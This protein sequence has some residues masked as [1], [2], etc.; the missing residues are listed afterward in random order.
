MKISRL[1]YAWIC[2]TWMSLGTAAGAL[3]G[4]VT[5]MH[6]D[7]E[8]DGREYEAVLQQL[9]KT[10]HAFVIKATDPLQ[11]ILTVGKRNLQWLDVINAHRG[12]ADKL[13]LSTVDSQV[14]IPIE[15]PRESNRTIVATQ[16]N[17]LKATLPKE[18]LAVLL[19][20][21]PLTD[22]VPVDDKTF[23]TAI[24]DVDRVY[25]MA[26][27]WLLQE[28]DLAEYATLSRK[29][30]RGYYFLNK[31]EELDKK[32]T[33]WFDQPDGV[34]NR[35]TPL[36]VNICHNTSGSIKTCSDLLT[37]SIDTNKNAKIFYDKYVVGARKLYQTFF[38]IRNPR[39][40]AI[41]SAD[42][43]NSFVLPFRKPDKLD[44]ENWLRDNIQDEW[45]LKA[46]QLT[47]NFITPGTNAAYVTFVAGATPNVNGLG[48][49]RIT[50]DANRN[51]QEY[52]TRWT[53]RH[54]FGHVIGY[55]DCYVEYYDADRQVMINYQ[56]DTTNLM[57]SRRGHIQEQHLA[58]MQ[59]AY[60]KKQGK[61]EQ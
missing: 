5:S 56:L 55:P 13:E 46:F 40:D 18:I 38:A 45:R 16:F 61:Q 51:I 11:D 1:H 26:S 57:C 30:I 19:A 39:S 50:M 37:K 6:L 41:Y 44:V 21:T 29:D 35:L 49:N 4:S 7:L 48:G 17:Q 3:A 52:V 58:A 22:T 42:K 20:T 27:R 9:A 28:P 47:L 14:G 53:I 54:E 33:T 36:L 32:L 8:M 2:T 24:R 59:D 25:Q 10:D 34:R 60:W 43:P 12:Q 31:E 15:Q 23:L